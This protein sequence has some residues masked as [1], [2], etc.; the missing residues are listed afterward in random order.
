MEYDD[1]IDYENESTKLDFKAVQYYGNKHEALLKDVMSMA[2]ADVEG[3]KLIVVG[4]NHKANGE[5]DIV[6]IEKEDFIDS[7]NYQQL[8]RKNIEPYIEISYEPHKYNGKNEE[9]N[10]KLIGIIKIKKS[11]NKPYMM[12]KKYEDLNQGDCFVRKGT[13]QDPMTRNDI[14][15]IFENKTS[16]NFED[17]IKIGFINTDYSKKVKLPALEKEELPSDRAAK[18]IKKI[19]EEK[20]NSE[21]ILGNSG[22]GDFNKM[23]EGYRHTFSSAPYEVRSIEELEKNLENV[24]ETYKDNDIYELFNRSYS[25]NFEIIN[26]D[27]AYIEDVI[28][29]LI[30]PKEEGLYI[31]HKFYEKPNNSLQSQITNL[32]YPNDSIKNYPKINFKEDSKVI[33]EQDVGEIKHHR[34]STIYKEAIR[35]WINSTLSGKTIELKGILY[36]KNL[37]EPIVKSFFIEIK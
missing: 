3:E 14:D 37:A 9:D 5:R 1:I 20:R 12:K 24:K 26:E 19:L 27:S 13:Q 17:N 6:G 22:F 36:G 18:K 8:I 21:D 23:M 4:V 10:G 15:K 11:D 2:N 28:F 16:N 35:V 33:V 29:K 32:Y 31:F 30:I 25:I 7:S 34:Y